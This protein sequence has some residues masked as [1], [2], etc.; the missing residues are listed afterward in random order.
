MIF[1]K[2]IQKWA[3]EKKPRVNFLNTEMQP[4]FPLA[5]LL[6]YSRNVTR[7]GAIRSYERL[8]RTVNICGW[9]PENRRNRYPWC[10]YA[11]YSLSE[12]QNRWIKKDKVG[13]E[14]KVSSRRATPPVSGELLLWSCRQHI[15]IWKQVSPGLNAN[16]YKLLLNTIT[17]ALPHIG[18]LIQPKRRHISCKGI[19]KWSYEMICR[20]N[21]SFI[22]NEEIPE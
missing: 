6:G 18:E 14:T 7:T 17:T 2:T 16:A 4:K 11:T 21:E 5:G 3:N 10:W 13:L 19:D 22:F 1:I 15:S 9:H 12:N 20:Q 8:L